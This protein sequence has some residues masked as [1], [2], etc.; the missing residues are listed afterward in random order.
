L[1]TLTNALTTDS[2]GPPQTFADAY[3]TATTG[4]GE[5]ASNF[6][7]TDGSGDPSS[8]TVNSNLTSGNMTL[9]QASAEPTA[10]AMSANFS[11]SASALNVTGTYVDLTTAIL[12]GFQEAAN[13][14]ATQNTAAAQ[15]KTY[16]QQ[17][18]TSAT[19]VNVDSELVNLTTLQNSYAASAHVITTINAM[20][21]DL[22]NVL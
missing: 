7:T 10:A 20:L 18:L 9:K 2:T 19:G 1:Q 6:F 3:N 5:L 16:Y 17:A 13:T 14:V 22:E 21:A 11:F 8:L 4:T 12:S 15:Q